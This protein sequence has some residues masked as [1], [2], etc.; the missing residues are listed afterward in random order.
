MNNNYCIKQNY[1]TCQSTLNITLDDNRGQLHWHHENKAP[2]LSFQWSTCLYAKKQLDSSRT[3]TIVDIGCGSALKAKRLFSE[4]KNLYYGIDQESSE[5]SFPALNNFFVVPFDLD[6]P[7]FSKIPS[8]NVDIIV[9]S[10]FTDHLIDPDKL[11][12]LMRYIASPSTKIIISI[13]CRDRL[14]GVQSM[15]S[16]KLEYIREWNRY[17]FITYL[18]VDG[19]T[20]KDSLSASPMRPK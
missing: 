20:I 3:Q 8:V 10:D 14:R 17:E 16:E 7:I 1:R 15:K 9:C 6:K 13:P 5:R 4:N 11:L 18:S 2:N 19:F 12:D